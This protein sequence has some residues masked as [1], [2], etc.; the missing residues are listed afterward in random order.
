MQKIYLIRYTRN[1]LPTVSFVNRHIEA[2]VIAR[3][4]EE[5]VAEVNNENNDITITN[6]VEK[7]SHV[8]SL[9]GT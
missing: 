3:T 6:V 9:R 7:N 5:A 1:N 2:T 8:L 4:E